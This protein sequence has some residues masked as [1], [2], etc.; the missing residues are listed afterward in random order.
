MRWFYRFILGLPALPEDIEELRR[1]LPELLNEQ[2][3]IEE[4][5]GPIEP[6]VIFLPWLPLEPEG[7]IQLRRQINNWLRQSDQP[8]NQP[9]LPYSS[10]PCSHP[11]CPYRPEN[12]AVIPANEASRKEKNFGDEDKSKGPEVIELIAGEYK[13]PLNSFLNEVRRIGKKAGKINQIILT[14]RYI[15]SE[16]S[17]YGEPVDY[18]STLIKFLKALNLEEKAD[19]ELLITPAPNIDSKEVPPR[20]EALKRAINKHL[21]KL[22]LKHH[23]TGIQIHDRFY[24]VQGNK[25]RY[26]LCGA[27]L[28]RISHKPGVPT[29]KVATCR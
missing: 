14:D 19:I 11:E 10:V 28:T 15:F 13:S 25:G 8:E 24:L 23:K 4:N 9:I 12:G 26:G 6:L 2:T 16:Y 17:E 18:D 29:I 5:E 3:S 1:T 7:S 22:R 21:P 20:T 27:S